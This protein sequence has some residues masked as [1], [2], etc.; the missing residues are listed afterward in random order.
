MK[1]LLVSGLLSLGLLSSG[2][3]AHGDYHHKE[4]KA[5]R[6]S[7]EEKPFGRSGDPARLSRTVSI[8]MDDTMHYSMDSVTVRQG[9]TIRFIARNRG[10]LMHEMVLGTPKDIEEHAELMRKFPNME[11]DEGYQLHVEPGSTGEMIWQFTRAGVFKFACLFP[12]H[13]EAGMHGKVIV[14]DDRSGKRLSR[15]TRSARGV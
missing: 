2:V 3:H 9:E 10:A 7:V 13:Y 6:S 5:D 8:D 4:P 12:G 15:A 14:L 11:H 1:L